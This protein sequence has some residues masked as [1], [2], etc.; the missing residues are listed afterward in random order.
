MLVWYGSHGSIRGGVGGCAFASIL[1][2]EFS[3]ISSK[4]TMIHGKK[5][6]SLS[7]LTAEILELDPDQKKWSGRIARE[8]PLELA[9]SGTG[10]GTS[11]Y[12]ENVGK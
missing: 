1:D 12:V 11:A 6:P 7:I 3:N 10:N 8:M 4:I 9:G 2:V 5:N